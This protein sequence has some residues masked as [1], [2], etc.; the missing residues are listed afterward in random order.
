MAAM[1]LT[2]LLKFESV[3]SAWKLLEA[4]GEG[5]LLGLDAILFLGAM[6]CKG[7]MKDFEEE[8]EMF[9]RLKNRGV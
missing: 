8:D 4:T 5:D 1:I 3:K 9:E 7:F 2:S 6:I